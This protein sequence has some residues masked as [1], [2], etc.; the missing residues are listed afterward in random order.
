MPWM[1]ALPGT[2]TLAGSKDGLC[3]FPEGNEALT[4]ECPWIAMG[5]GDSLPRFIDLFMAAL[6]ICCCMRALFS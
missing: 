6:G 1:D 2:S 4:N 3:G 5:F